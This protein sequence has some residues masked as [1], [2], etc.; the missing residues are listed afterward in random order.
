MSVKTQLCMF[1]VRIGEGIT[2]KDLAV[3]A[4]LDQKVEPRLCNVIDAMNAALKMDLL[5]LLYTEFN[6]GDA[7]TI[8]K[9][10]RLNMSGFYI[11][12]RRTIFAPLKNILF[13]S[14]N[15]P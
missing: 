7:L 15:C 11:L 2:P 3:I 9:N 10:L 6:F 1:I 8:S 14:K 4:G 12:V 13:L 5:Q